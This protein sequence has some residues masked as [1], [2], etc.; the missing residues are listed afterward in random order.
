MFTVK[1]TYEQLTQI[2]SRATHKNSWEAKI[3]LKIKY[4]LWALEN[5]ACYFCKDN[6]TINHLLF[7]CKVAKSN[8]GL[9]SLLDGGNC[10]PNSI[11]QCWL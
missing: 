11:Q 2:E 1:S 7:E 9:Y 4:F 6:E 10:T 8:W 3:P 5:D